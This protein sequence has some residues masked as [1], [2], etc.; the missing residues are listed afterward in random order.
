MWREKLLGFIWQSLWSCTSF[1]LLGQGLSSWLA[2]DSK[3]RFFFA[4]LKNIKEYKCKNNTNEM[5]RLQKKKKNACSV[6]KEKCCALLMAPPIQLHEDVTRIFLMAAL[7]L[8]QTI[9]GHLPYNP[10]CCVCTHSSC[11]TWRGIAKAGEPGHLT[12]LCH[13]ADS[14]ILL[15]RQCRKIKC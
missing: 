14:Y 12:K 8:A 2:A 5:T 9:R 6:L 13:N 10:L 1:P 11:R 15:L 7:G 4:T 3:L